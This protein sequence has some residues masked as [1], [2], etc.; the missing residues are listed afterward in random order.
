MS[1]PVRAPPSR[2]RR[3]YVRLSIRLAHGAD[4]PRDLRAR[5]PHPVRRL[6]VEW[7]GKAPVVL[8]L[9]GLGRTFRHSHLH[10][11]ANP[12]YFDT[13]RCLATFRGLGPTTG[14]TTA[15]TRDPSLDPRCLWRRQESGHLGRRAPMRCVRY[16]EPR[17][18]L[19]HDCASDDA[20]AA[21][22]S[23]SAGT[24]TAARSAASACAPTSSAPPTAR[25]AARTA[26]AA[27]QR[28][29]RAAPCSTRA[30]RADGNPCAANTDARSSS[31]KR[32]SGACA[33]SPRPRARS[34]RAECC[35]DSLRHH[36]GPYGRPLH[37]PDA[38]Q[39]EPL[40]RR[41]RHGVQRMPGADCCSRLCEVYA[42]TGVRFASRPKAAASHGDICHVDNDCAARPV[43]ACP[44][45]AT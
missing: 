32:G 9:Y 14:A 24:P 20:R 12:R 34:A 18:V 6:H 5:R 45:M 10:E 22:A 29:R 44:A 31:C 37:P 33:A 21:G 39:H 17:H 16:S 30:A 13:Q 35:G 23:C 3:H 40:G 11:R 19:L 38:R 15:L 1:A 28:D 43:P 4:R 2:L 26:S 42:P 8:S 36:A 41:R 25:R 27:V 7:C